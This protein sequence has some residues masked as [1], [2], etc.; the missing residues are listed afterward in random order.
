MK[1]LKLSDLKV[2]SFVTNLDKTGQHIL[3]GQNTLVCNTVYP[4]CDLLRTQNVC[5]GYSGL[6]PNCPF[7]FTGCVDTLDTSCG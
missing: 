1:K 3:G 2:Q 5:T 7:T 4:A 6:E